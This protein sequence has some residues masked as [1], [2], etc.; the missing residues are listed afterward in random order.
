MNWLHSTSHWVASFPFSHNTIQSPQV[1]VLSSAPHE[2][3]PQLVSSEFCPFHGFPLC[4]M[5]L[6]RQVKPTPLRGSSFGRRS[7]HI[8]TIESTELD[9]KTDR[10]EGWLWLVARVCGGDQRPLYRVARFRFQVETFNWKFSNENVRVMYHC[11][12]N[13]SDLEFQNYSNHPALEVIRFARGKRIDYKASIAMH[14]LHT[15]A[16]PYTLCS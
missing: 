7:V 3:T 6:H 5:Q 4:W 2:Q 16:A 1:L 8:G 14:P 13:Y 10:T 15:C 12:E 11:S 9:R